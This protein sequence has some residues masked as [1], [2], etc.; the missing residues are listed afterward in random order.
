M[1]FTL[2][3]GNIAHNAYFNELNLR[4]EGKEGCVAVFDAYHFASCPEWL[5]LSKEGVDKDSLG[6]DFFPNFFQFPKS[7]KLRPDWF[8]QGPQLQL[9][10]CIYTL[11]SKHESKSQDV[12]DLSRALL[13]F[14]RFK[15][16][17]AQDYS[18]THVEWTLDHFQ[19]KTKDLTVDESWFSWLKIG[20][21]LEQKRVKF[22][23]WF[24]EISVV[25]YELIHLPM[26]IHVFEPVL[27]THKAV[28]KKYKETHSTY[29][30]E[31]IIEEIT[32]Y[33]SSK[34]R[35]KI[36]YN[37]D[38]IDNLIALG[39]ISISDVLYDLSLREDLDGLKDLNTLP[40][41]ATLP[42]WDR[43]RELFEHHI[44]YGPH[45]VLPGLSLTKMP[46]AAY[47]HGT[48]RSLPFED[49][50]LGR[51]IRYGFERADVVMITNADYMKAKPRLEFDPEKI[52]YIP[53]GFDDQS[54]LEF[55]QS[56]QK[57]KSVNDTINFFA[58]ARHT[59]TNG[60][61]GNS[62][63]NQYIVQAVAELVAQGTTNFC[64][65]M[66]EYGA[67]V[68]AT[69][70]LIEELAVKA[71]FVWRDTMTREEL[72]VNY[73]NSHAVL[74]QFY[75]P[76]I[77]QIG[78]ETLALGCRLINAD[79]GSLAEY[80]E[81]PSPILPGNSVPE[82]VERM[83]SIIEDPDDLKGLGKEAVR[84]FEENHSE[85]AITQKLIRTL[86]LLDQ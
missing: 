67:D 58:P 19:Q 41:A 29:F 74:D 63:G 13:D 72:W 16:I 11:Y 26:S 39:I 48:I 14:Q 33:F 21:E 32:K 20:F 79:D 1:N 82:I 4:R 76:A 10:A 44:F 17:A 81:S 36:I 50:D 73:L 31:E 35:E 71:F 12:C 51:L 43:V 25:Q 15:C 9:L 84:W 85:S 78:V 37:L 68:D 45:V 24:N 62:K 70:N 59:W 57:Q 28:L 47:E 64:V 34:R 61:D 65:L 5:A 2:H 27:K 53:H 80:F 8:I 40:Y 3:V 7:T 46:Y 83:Q 6:D 38:N 75:I 66:I 23:Q 55:K 86:N 49:S 54:C 18:E 77:G 22:L 30:I 60:D 42:Y 69:K 56:Y 52:V